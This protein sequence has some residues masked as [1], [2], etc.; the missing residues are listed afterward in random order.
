MNPK[1]P[2]IEYMKATYQ[3]L[4][5]L[6]CAELVVTEEIMRE[7]SAVMGKLEGMRLTLGLPSGWWALV[8]FLGVGFFTAGCLFSSIPIL[9]NSVLQISGFVFI[10][11]YPLVVPAVRF[12]EWRDKTDGI[13]NCGTARCGRD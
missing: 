10:A 4:F 7:S 13:A 12:R 11:G 6:Y 9:E 2:R 1:G 5:S 8:I 3:L